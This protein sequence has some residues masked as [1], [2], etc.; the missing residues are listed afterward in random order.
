[1]SNPVLLN[2]IDHAALRVITSRGAAYG[3]N[4]MSALTFPDEFRTLQAHYPIVFRKNADGSFEALALFG[5]QEGENL[6]LE[7]DAWLVPDLPLTVERQPFLIGVDGE[8][9]MVHVDLDSPRLSTSEGEPLFLPQGGTSDYLE[10]MNSTLRAIHLGLQG[11]RG[12]VGALL[13]HDL[14][15][16]FVF[17]IELDDGSNNRLAGFYTIHEERLA[18]LN[19]AALERLHRAGYL[20]A[21]YMVLASMSNFRTLID[22]KNRKLQAHAGGR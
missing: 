12:F 15:E 8:Q 4:A 5:F 9:L 20:Q 17:D 7:G 22:R 21:A 10:R 16:S 19:G 2:N 13:E 6:F 3:D 11:A 14:L 1:M 18:A